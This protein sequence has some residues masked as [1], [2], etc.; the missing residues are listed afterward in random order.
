M[1]LT[2]L[3]CEGIF[4]IGGERGPQEP[5]GEPISWSG[6]V[7]RSP[8]AGEE[9]QLESGSVWFSPDDGEAVEAEQLYDDYPGY[10]SVEID[11]EVPVQI[12]LETETAWPTVWRATTPGAG[13]SW[14]SGALFAADMEYMDA[15][16]AT[17]PGTGF[18]SPG[19]LADGEV[20]HLWGSPY[21]SGWDAADVRVNG[22]PADCFT[23]ADDGTL[24]R[25]TSGELDY[26]TAFDLEPGE[27]TVESGLGGSETWNVSGGEW[28]F[29]FFF[30]GNP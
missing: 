27:V 4:E 28:I 18:A 20:A 12:R 9:T 1:I 22:E 14:L 29:A 19:D 26:F 10:W 7:Y 5:D 6:Y 11:P 8:E 16:V 3:A 24:E 25:V 30:V 13:A 23:V 21:D 15:W 2:L 17:L